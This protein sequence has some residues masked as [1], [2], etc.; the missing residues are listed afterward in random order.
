MAAY[1]A[2]LRDHRPLILAARLLRQ[3][4]FQKFQSQDAVARE[5]PAIPAIP[6]IRAAV[7]AVAPG[8]LQLF[9]TGSV[10]LTMFF[11]LTTTEEIPERVGLGFP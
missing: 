4:A 9:I 6:A 8:G 2:S 1:L 7:A 10:L 5:V 3:Q 11:A